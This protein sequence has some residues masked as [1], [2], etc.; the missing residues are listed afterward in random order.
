MYSLAST[1]WDNEEIQV[2]TELLMSGK[3]TM[4]KKVR[5]FEEIFANYIG[6]KYA[7]MFNSGSSANLAMIAAL[8]YVKNSRIND[9]D[10]VIVPAVSWST[11]FYPI[12]QLG[13]ILD[14]VDIDLET[15]NLD[16]CEVE[17]KITK[18]TK[19]IFAVN[20][21]GNPSDL[22]SLQQICN[23]H[24]LTL[25][26]DNCEALGASINGQMTGSFGVMSSH[27]FYF[28]HHI[29][30]ME[31]GMVTTSSRELMETLVSLRAHGWTRELD[32]NNSVFPKLDNS[33]E[34]LFRFVLPGYNL[35]PLEISGAIGKVQI[36]KFPEFLIQRIKNANFFINL[37]KGSR[38]YLVQ[39]EFGTSSWFGF[40][41]VLINELSGKREALIK[42]LSSFHIETRP[43]VAGNFTLNPVMKHLK[44][45]KLTS[46]SNAN[47]IH[48]NG[49]F[50]GNHHYDV[51]SQLNEVH[52][53]LIQFEKENT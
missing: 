37:F 34:D 23:Q 1:T 39:K 13:L 8:R 40:S 47:L 15:L 28:S 41:I 33:W 4:G 22:K 46:L 35:R 11:T 45:S 17:K 53:L 3:L 43:I 24:N 21:L 5:E 7:V 10:H 12:N 52:R 14:F 26:E 25:I 2:A 16:V 32:K 20:L 38:N 27:S 6:T 51:I 50:I 42:F 19:A 30:T 31:G 48:N 9:G 29:S 44:F 49:L 18:K 36:N